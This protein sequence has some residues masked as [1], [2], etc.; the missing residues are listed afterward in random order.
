M[1]TAIRASVFRV[2]R[3]WFSRLSHSTAVRITKTAIGYQLSA[4]SFQLVTVSGLSQPSRAF[5]REG[6]RAEAALAAEADELRAASYAAFLS[7]LGATVEAASGH[8]RTW[9]TTWQLSHQMA[10]E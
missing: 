6:C 7:L 9:W 2:G 4:L 8:A 3:E 10:A 5:H 1:A